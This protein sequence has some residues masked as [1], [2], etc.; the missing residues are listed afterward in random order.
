MHASVLSQ[1]QLERIHQASLGILERVGVVIPHPGMLSRL[2]DFG[3][4]VDFDRQRARLKPDF[5]MDCVRKAGKS[6]TLYG[7]DRQRTAAFGQGQ[8][9][10]NSIAGEAYWLD[11]PGQ[12]RRFATL[13]DVAATAR[14]CHNL[15]EINIVGAMSDPHEVPIAARCVEVLA[16]LVRHTD[17]AADV[18]VPRPGLDPLRGRAADRAGRLGRGGRAATRSATRSW[19]RSARCASRSTGSTCC[20][21]PPG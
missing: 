21:R 2:A 7:R 17:Q 8:R 1:S 10:Y 13:E 20:S 4:R 11:E 12:D 9:N 16:T 5:V 3:Q 18:L 19:S 6:F 15:P 14:F